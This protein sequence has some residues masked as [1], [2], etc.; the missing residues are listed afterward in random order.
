M[1]RNLTALVADLARYTDGVERARREYAL[2]PNGKCYT[3]CPCP[4]AQR[5]R[6]RK[7]STKETA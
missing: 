6:K 7:R 2:H 4:V 3:H 1:I 5:R